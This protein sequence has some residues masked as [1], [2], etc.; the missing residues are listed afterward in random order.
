MRL[1]LRTMLAYLDDMLEPQDAHDLGQRIETSEFATNLVHRIRSST[2]RVKLPA[3]EVGEEGIGRSEVSVAQYL[4]NTLPVHEVAEFEKTCLESESH[5][6]E[7]AGCHQILTLVLGEPAQIDEGVRE[8]I[9][10][11]GSRTVSIDSGHN[12]GLDP[13]RHHSSVAPATADAV[14][15]QAPS[16][17]VAGQSMD[18]DTAEKKPRDKEVPDYLKEGSRLRVWPLV[19][20]IVLACFLAGA[21]VMALGPDRW[22]GKSTPEDQQVADGQATGAGDATSEDESD[23][24]AAPATDTTP[25]PPDTEGA[26]AGTS[27]DGTPTPPTGVTPEPSSDTGGADVS[28]PTSPE[29][30][31]LAPPLTGDADD[32]DAGS[33]PGVTPPAP[34]DEVASVDPDTMTPPLPAVEDGAP[35]PPVAAPVEVGR[36]L[37]DNEVLA[38]YDAEDDVWRREPARAALMSN[39]RL[40]ALPVF[41]PQLMLDSIQLTLDGGTEIELEPLTA[42]GTPVISVRS[43]RLV[44]ATMGKADTAITIKTPHTS[45][46]IRFGNADGVA[47]VDCG[48]FLP[49]G[50]NPLA[51]PQHSLCQIYGVSG[52]VTWTQGDATQPIGPGE[53]YEFFDDRPGAVVRVAETPAWIATNPAS[54]IDAAAAKVLVEQLTSDRPLG[55]TLHELAQDRRTEVRSLSIRALGVL[56]DFDEFPAAFADEGQRS[57]WD[58]HFDALT[59]A[60]T[61]DAEQAEKVRLA[62]VKHR[63]PAADELFRMLWGYSPDQLANGSA[64]QLVSY[65]EAEDLDTRVLAFENLYRITG[66]KLLYLPQAPIT[67]RRSSVRRWEERL[68]SGEIVYRDPPRTIEVE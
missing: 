23:A 63:G 8:R 1:T 30:A 39:D 36:Y 19:I 13:Q 51:G 15:P 46:T 65:L 11:I 50:E 48:G 34:G 38:I 37:S 49:A 9:Y 58:E 56:G 32:E 40:V 3:P 25:T 29:P 4:D 33:T 14:A 43:G 68:K 18:A 54:G 26:D 45:G 20:T 60:V 21:I 17:A 64:A 52:D 10:R 35:V 27:P 44:V 57:S 2:R 22:F 6:A 61:A 24:D 59:A 31:P 28:P 53:M 5:L 42:E 41:R 66:A 55:L 12:A 62:F 7:V 47:A 16:D 67:T